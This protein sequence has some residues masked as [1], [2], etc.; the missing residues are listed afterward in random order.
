MS[1]MHFPYIADFIK[2]RRS[3]HFLLFAGQGIFRCGRNPVTSD[4]VRP[5]AEMQAGENNRRNQ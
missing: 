5:R 4:D 3:V 1:R 2:I